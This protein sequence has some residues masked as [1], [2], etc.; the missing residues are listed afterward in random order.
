[1]TP[2]YAEEIH[3]LEGLD[4]DELENY[5]EE[6]P[7]I[8]PLLEIDV[9]ETTKTYTTP[10]TTT[11]QDYEPNEESVIELHPPHDA[12]D[13]EMEI[14]RRVVATVL[15]EI[16]VGSLEAPQALLTA[17]DLPLRKKPP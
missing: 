13:R 4:D 7:Q 5:M 15:G 17:K 6:N 9:M 10:A 16:N 1:M 8:V 12:F 2:L 14:S 3:M 11:E